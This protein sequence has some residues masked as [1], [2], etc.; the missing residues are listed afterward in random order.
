[1]IFGNCCIETMTA[2]RIGHINFGPRRRKKY[3]TMISMCVPER[4]K[5]RLTCQ[6][7]KGSRGV[8]QTPVKEYPS[9]GTIG[10]GSAI[11]NGEP[12]G[13][14][15]ETGSVYPGSAEPS[16]TNSSLTIRRPGSSTVA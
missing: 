15:R 12:D 11:G 13:A 4:V 1:M 14:P 8:D 9:C 3:A 5:R 16:P 10:R 2:L 7:L 6:V